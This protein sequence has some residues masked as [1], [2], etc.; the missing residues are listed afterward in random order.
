MKVLEKLSEFPEVKPKLKGLAAEA[1][2]H[3]QAVKRDLP[4]LKV[5]LEGENVA[6]VKRAFTAA[7]KHMKGAVESRTAEGNTILVKWL[8]EGRARRVRGTGPAKIEHT[9]EAIAAEVK[10]LWDSKGVK[11]SPSA[12]DK[13]KL[14][15]SAKRNLSR[16]AR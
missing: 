12:T 13:R 1:L 3:L 9:A 8:A 15:V 5:Q 6:A 7:A 11:G 14:E 4:V 16:R 10:R 2:S